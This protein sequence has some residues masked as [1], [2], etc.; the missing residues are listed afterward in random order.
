MNN[1]SFSESLYTIPN[2]VVWKPFDQA[3]YNSNSYN[4]SADYTQTYLVNRELADKLMN[5]CY[6]ALKTY[7]LFPRDTGHMQDES[8]DYESTPTGFNLFIHDKDIN[9]GAPYQ[10]YLEYG[11]NPHIIHN[12]F[13]KGFSVV[14]PGSNK[15]VGFW[16]KNSYAVVVDAILNFTNGKIE[17]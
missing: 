1:N 13:G 10:Y 11:T 2:D 7:S 15:H 6:Y 5:V 16:S 14:H 4:S 12:A 9:K 17:N 8:L 3:S